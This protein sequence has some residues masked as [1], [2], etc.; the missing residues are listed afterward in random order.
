[1]SSIRINMNSPQKILLAR[2]LN[3]NGVGQTKFTKECA[4]AFNNYVPYDK[5][6]L[7]DMMVNLEATKIIYSAPYAKKQYYNNK[8]MGKQGNS[9]G[10]KRGKLWDRRSWIDNGNNIVQTIANFCGGHT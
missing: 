4:K 6:R 10:G 5:G 1:M 9:S 8:G 7:K 3:K 2:S